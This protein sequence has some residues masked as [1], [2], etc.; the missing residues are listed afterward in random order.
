MPRKH[1]VVA[2]RVL[3]SLDDELAASGLARGERLTWSAAEVELLS[4]L[5]NSIDRRTR[6]AT[7]WEQADDPKVIVKLSTELRQCDTAV[8]R[9][10]R[11]IRT[12][13]SGPDSQITVKNR[14]AANT[15]WDR[16]HQR[17]HA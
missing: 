4:T 9:L 15:R 2:R 13:V 16:E 10:L 8:M 1:G 11:A 17:A 5:A 7:L 3:A 14:R 6:I 12:D